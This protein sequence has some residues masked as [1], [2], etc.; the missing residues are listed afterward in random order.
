[1]EKEKNSVYSHPPEIRLLKIEKA[2]N[3]TAQMR[4]EQSNVA[5]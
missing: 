4:M 5:Y 3:G 1:M 2:V